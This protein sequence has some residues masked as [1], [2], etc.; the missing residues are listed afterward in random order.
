M[1]L[2]NAKSN[3][4]FTPEVEGENN[5]YFIEDFD[6]EATKGTNNVLML[7]DEIIDGSVV[8]D[9]GCAQ[10]NFGKILKAKKCIIY[11]IEKNKSAAEKAL[12]S[13]FYNNVFLTDLMDMESAEFKRFSKDIFDADVIILSDVLEHLVEP[14]KAII[15]YS[16]FLRNNGIILISIPNIAHIDIILNLMNGRFNYSDLGILDNTHLKFFTKSSFLE[17]IIQ[18]NNTSKEIKFDCEYLGSTFYNNDFIQEIKTNYPQL[19]SILEQCENFNSLQIL[20]K[21]KKIS[22]NE[23]VKNLEKLIL[24]PKKDIV[25]TLGRALKNVFESNGVTQT[26]KGER[27]W[28]ERQI[29][30]LKNGITWHQ[31]ND[32]KSKQY[33]RQL[34]NRVKELEDG[35]AWHQNND[36]KSKQYIQQLENRVKELEDGIAWH[37]DNDIKRKQY[38]QRLENRV[39]ELENGIVWHQDNDEKSK[40][41][42]QQ[43]E[44]RIRELDG[45]IIWHN[46]NN[47][48]LSKNIIYLEDQLKISE[49][50]NNILR[51][52]IYQMESS[53][54]WKITK[55]MRRH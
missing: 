20:F 9:I 31:N 27:F 34:E 50:K 46:S 51:S 42:I 11:G 41:Y 10:G 24:E 2:A 16:K 36:I 3:R 15:N 26:S 4:F 18:I 43:L 44:N 53:L 55:W 14:T 25:S 37:Q 22:K 35:I 17:W 48:D 13:G 45:H 47:E 40:L 5:R 21:L 23:E 19:F 28:F 8:I 1:E 39:K 49:N 32:I 6:A 29:Q 33:I 30:T 12:K 38:T 54:S 7:T 52:K